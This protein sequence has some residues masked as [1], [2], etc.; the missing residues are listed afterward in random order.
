MSAG[1]VIAL[2]CKQVVLAA[3]SSLGPIDAQVRGHSA[4]AIIDEFEHARKEIQSD[5][6]AALLWKPILDK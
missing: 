1:T 4:D 6:S 5:E 3:H 2:A